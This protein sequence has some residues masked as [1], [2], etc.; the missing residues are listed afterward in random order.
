[1]VAAVAV[2]GTDPG[3]NVVTRNQVSFFAAEYRPQ[4]SVGMC[5]GTRNPKVVPLDSFQYDDPMASIPW[6]SFIST[7]P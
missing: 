4:I 1:M 7:L 3:A 2:R 6:Q 5:Q